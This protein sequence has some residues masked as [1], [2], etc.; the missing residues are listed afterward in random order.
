MRK[1][2]QAFLWD[3][4]GETLDLWPFIFLAISMLAA[5]AAPAIRSHIA[6]FLA[7]GG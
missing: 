3:R 1:E 7:S 5:L 6:R 4:R 2:I